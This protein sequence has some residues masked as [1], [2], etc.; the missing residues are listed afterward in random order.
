MLNT[1]EHLKAKGWTFKAISP[2]AMA[3]VFKH[4]HTQYVWQPGR[5]GDK[6]NFD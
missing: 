2:V 4:K 6:L 3:K 5:I 1:F